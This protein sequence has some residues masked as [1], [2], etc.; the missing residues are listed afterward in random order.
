MRIKDE[1][2]KLLNQ[3][4]LGIKVYILAEY[5]MRLICL[6]LFHMLYFCSILY[7]AFHDFAVYVKY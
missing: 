2:L 3:V 7:Q 5:D 6:Y 4:L 1:R